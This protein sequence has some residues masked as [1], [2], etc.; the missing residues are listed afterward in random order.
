MKLWNSRSKGLQCKY[1]KQ[2]QV[3]SRL[4][5]QLEMTPPKTNSSRR[6]MR[7][8]SSKISSK[9]SLS[10]EPSS[11]W[12]STMYSFV[13]SKVSMTT[14][15]AVISR[16]TTWCNKSSHPEEPPKCPQPSSPRPSSPNLVNNLLLKASSPVASHRCNHRLMAAMGCPL[17][18]CS[19]CPSLWLPTLMA[20]LLRCKDMVSL[21]KVSHPKCKDTVN[22]CKATVN[23]CKVMDS[24]CKASSP[25][26]RVTASQCRA[27][28]SLCKANSL[29]CK[30]GVCLNS[31]SSRC[32]DSRT[33]TASKSERLA[34]SKVKA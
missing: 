20:S 15:L 22:L 30:A 12:S 27:M 14:S 7:L 28:D 5:T 17:R 33:L 21:C 26:C 6:S 1:N 23:Q 25:Q 18:T 3:C 9:F 10:R 11:T 13:C 16:K 4:L 2:L 8:L 19:K 29:R 31:S 32:L 24:P 34:I